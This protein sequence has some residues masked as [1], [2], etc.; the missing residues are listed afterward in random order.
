M[1]K[2]KDILSKSVLVGIT[3]E[4]STGKTETEQ[5]LGVFEKMDDEAI[6]LRREDGS[7]ATL[8]P[9]LES[10]T[11]AEPAVYRLKCSGEQVVNPDYLSCWTMK[12]PKK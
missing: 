8:P 1:V 4:I 5:Y 12:K 3:K 6:Y 11:I 9:C 7:I 10:F 2:L